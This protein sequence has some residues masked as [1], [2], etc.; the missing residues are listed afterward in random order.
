MTAWLGNKVKN[1]PLLKKIF[2]TFVFFSI[3]QHASTQRRTPAPRGMASQHQWTVPAAYSLFAG[4]VPAAYSL[5]AG[6]VPGFN[7][8]LKVIDREQNKTSLIKA[9]P[10]QCHVVCVSWQ[11]HSPLSGITSVKFMN[12]KLNICRLKDVLTKIRS[13]KLIELYL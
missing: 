1:V 13:D 9:W 12:A 11:L 7:L 2:L 5:F 8:F 10:Y 4:T 3:V 6:T